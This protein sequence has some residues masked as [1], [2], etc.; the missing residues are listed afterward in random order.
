MNGINNILV[1]C[2]ITTDA[3]PRHTYN[4]SPIIRSPLYAGIAPGNTFG[5]IIISSFH[6]NDAYIEADRSNTNGIITA[7]SS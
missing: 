3:S 7:C 2:G 4:I 1:G 6:S 5:V